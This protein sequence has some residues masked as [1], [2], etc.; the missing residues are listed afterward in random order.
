[1][2]REQFISYVE[3]SQEAFRRFLLALCCG[4]HALADDIAQE[5]YIKA[6]LASDRL[7]EP[8]KFNSWL[9]QIGYN[10]FIN[11]ARALKASTDLDA[12]ADIPASEITDGAFQYEA[13]YAALRRMPDKERTAVILFYI[14]DYPIKKIA[15][16]VGASQSAVKQHLSR[17]RAHLRGLLTK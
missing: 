6:Y 11:Q 7:T 16:I 14:D 9:R 1:M 5:S 10:T 12:A 8:E 17:G 2:T 15:D 13:L 4:N 3:A